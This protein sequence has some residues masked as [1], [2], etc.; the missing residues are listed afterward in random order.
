MCDDSGTALAAKQWNDGAR[1]VARDYS[2]AGRRAALQQVWNLV[3]RAQVA[4]NHLVER[5]RRDEALEELDWVA[6]KVRELF[7]RCG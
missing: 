2:R 4:R 5:G 1:Q 7:E 6:D 3:H